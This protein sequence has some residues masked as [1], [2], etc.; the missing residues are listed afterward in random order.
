MKFHLRKISFLQICIISLFI[1]TSVSSSIIESEETD[2]NFVKIMI[3][4]VIYN[5]YDASKDYV[6]KNVF[7]FNQ[8]SYFQGKN[9]NTDYGKKYCR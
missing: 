8:D 5:R 1:S 6:L 3:D 7:D 9:R 4:E 2:I